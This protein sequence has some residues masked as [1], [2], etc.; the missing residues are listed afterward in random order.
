MDSVNIVR[1]IKEGYAETP[2]KDLGK[3]DELKL[4]EFVSFALRNSFVLVADQN[5]RL[6]G[7]IS[8]APIRIPWCTAVV[9][10]EQWFAVTSAYRLRGVPEQL[11]GAVEE[12]LEE[13]K[14]PALLGTQMLTPAVLDAA[15]AKRMGGKFGGYTVSRTTY[16]RMPCRYSDEKG[17]PVMPPKKS[18][19]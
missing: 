10:T 5:G 1:L 18:A 12:F 9:M 13:N 8:L 4:L 17:R 11:L 16:L 7:S 14:R 3:L 15:I 6:L 19:A 2:A